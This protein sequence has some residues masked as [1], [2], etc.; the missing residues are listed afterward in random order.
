MLQTGPSEMLFCLL[1]TI[2][3]EDLYIVQYLVYYSNLQMCSSSLH[4]ENDR[5]SGDCSISDPYFA[6]I[7]LLLESKEA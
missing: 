4:K 6:A 7:F 5:Y 2:P 1:K 3:S